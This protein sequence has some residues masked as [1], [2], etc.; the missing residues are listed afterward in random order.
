LSEANHLRA[1]LKRGNHEGNHGAHEL[2][3]CGPETRD[4]TSM[5]CA[6]AISEKVKD[7]RTS[8]WRV[9]ARLTK[10][11]CVL[12]TTSAKGIERGRFNRTT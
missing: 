8:G 1:N 5:A 2:H 4:G 11:F 12:A 7:R 9:S 10:R 6:K 3:V